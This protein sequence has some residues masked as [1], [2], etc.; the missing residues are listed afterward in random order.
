MRRARL[1][2]LAALV[3]IA[4]QAPPTPS[5]PAGAERG[6]IATTAPAASGPATTGPAAGSP[7]TPA[8]T[9]PG[10]PETVRVGIN[11]NPTDAT[12]YWAQDHGYLR[13]Q[14]LDL[15]TTTF[16]GAQL[17]IAPLSADQL[18]VG[19]G[20]PGPGLFNAILRGINVRIVADR[21]RAVPGTRFN[22]LVVRKS[23]I[24]SGAVRGFAD[25]R[26]RVFAENVPDVITTYVMEKQLQQA[27]LG[28]DDLT[29][30]T[31]SFPDILT[32]LGNDAV[33]A[34]FQ[35]EPF[36]TLGEQRGV[37]DCWRPTSD[38]EPNFQIAVLLYGPTFAE[39]RADVGRRFMVAYL[40]AIRDYY[41]AFFGDGE[42]RAELL[43]IIARITNSRDRGLLERLAPSW[44]DPNGSVNVDSLRAVE[45]W[46]RGKGEVTAPV[47]FDQ[48]VDM[49][50]VN[51]AV[52]H[53]GPYPA[54]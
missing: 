3:L 50:F 42:G 27:G 10:E 19:G 7:T 32:G 41:R 47:D 33:D 46:Y 36:I 18:D 45:E 22:C 12:F 1:S 24:D 26:G 38:L 23:L 4:C 16:N 51:D 44:M 34:A 20:G 13:E 31:L 6:A 52:Q 35:V 14:G 49:S 15:D 43:D 28:L 9:G 48:V 37:S 40:R 5:P 11:N 17:M 29:L 30:T 39:E 54:Q 53:L 8:T 2:I 21:A 25:F